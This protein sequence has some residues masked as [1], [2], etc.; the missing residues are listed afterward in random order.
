VFMT[1]QMGTQVMIGPQR[2]LVRGGGSALLEEKSVGGCSSGV[3]QFVI[4]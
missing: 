3:S 4:E 1:G 2:G